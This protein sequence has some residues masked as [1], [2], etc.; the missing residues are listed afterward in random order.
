MIETKLY[1]RPEVEDFI[2]QGKVLHLCGTAEVLQGLPKGNWIAGTSA[3]F[4]SGEGVVSSDKIFVNDFTEVA[5]GVEFKNFDETNIHTIADKEFNGFIFL[6]IPMD[7]KVMSEYAHNCMSYKN[8]FINPIVGYIAGAPLSEIEFS[9]TYTATGDIGVFS[10]E[11]ASAM[12][13]TLKEGLTARPEIIYLDE[14]APDSPKITFPKTGYVQSDCYLDGAPANI[15]DYLTKVGLNGKMYCDIMSDLGGA[16]ICKGTRKVDTANKEVTFY[17]PPMEGDVYHVVRK[18]GDYAD[19]FNK[20][21]A[22]RRE[23]NDVMFCIGCI[24]YFVGGELEGRKMDFNLP[25]CFG[26]IIYEIVNK[27]FVTLEIDR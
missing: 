1:T 21:I 18:K 4:A 20:M 14:T 2:R 24:N 25:F 23:K 10:S 13:V 3:Y 9:K 16:K 15:A 8:L 27:T 5:N 19:D 12:Y 17:I 26:E 11:K 7:S 22:S 6:I